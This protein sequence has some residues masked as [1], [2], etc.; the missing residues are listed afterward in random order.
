MTCAL[1][2]GWVAG[3]SLP[4]KSK[5]VPR[6]LPSDKEA[7]KKGGTADPGFGR[8]ANINKRR[9]RGQNGAAS[10]EVGCQEAPERAVSA[11]SSTWGA[12]KMPQEV[13]SVVADGAENVGKHRKRKKIHAKRAQQQKKR[14]AYRCGSGLSVG[15][16]H[17]RA[18]GRGQ[19]WLTGY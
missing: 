18:A 13:P 16:K 1:C 7:T 15:S 19:C 12:R 10:A 3:C 14:G 9:K 6:R 11:D 8:D 17:G 2:A 4:Q 5:E